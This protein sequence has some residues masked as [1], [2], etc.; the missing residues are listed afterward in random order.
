MAYV[1]QFTITPQLLSEAEQVAV[2]R[3]RVQG[4][5]VDLAWIPSLQKD[6][7]TR[8]VHASTAIEGN[9]LTLEQ[10]RAL[11]EGRGLSAPGTRHKREVLNYFAGLRYVEKNA[12]K[13]A[14]RHAHI[15]ELHRI[16]AGEVMDQGEAGKYRMISVRVGQYRPPPADAVSG[17][18]FE[19]LEWWNTAAQK[20][21]PVLSSAIL[22][23]RFEAIHP[24]ADG[25]GR[26]G[27]ALA[28]W[29]LYRRG[30]DTHHIYSVDEYYWEDRPKYYAALEGVRQAG[31][32]LSSWLEYC[33][34]GLRQTLER[35]W[36]RIQTFQVQSAEKLV[37]RPRQEQLLHLLR[38]HG[39]MAPGEIWEALGVS[40]QGAMD[41]LRPLLDVGLVEK[42]G[43]KKT[44]R[45]V[46]RNP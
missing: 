23:Y 15:L 24:F 27:R 3:E 45:Y 11:E 46:L 36:L 5:A 17:L 39:S 25:N 16:L 13:K 40:R 41:L 7:R 30:F 26:T 1:P 2:L 8:N 35:A 21:S 31:E 44:G 33:A 29:E 12:A 19:L 37:L 18:M 4:A 22:H 9:P 20:L 42:V 32:D 43:G 28:L 34:A 38:D 10:V 14:V 6:T